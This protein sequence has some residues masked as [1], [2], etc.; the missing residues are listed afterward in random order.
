MPIF[1]DPTRPREDSEPQACE[2]ASDRVWDAP[3]KHAVPPE[4]LAQHRDMHRKVGLQLRD[5]ALRLIEQAQEHLSLAGDF[6]A[7]RERL[8][9]LAPGEKSYA[10]HLAETPTGR[11]RKTADL[12]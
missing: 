8:S 9:M 10:E 1:Y 5:Q 3:P 7:A 12:V 2:A 6:E 4:V 11:F